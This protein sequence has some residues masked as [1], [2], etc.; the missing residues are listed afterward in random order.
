[1][2]RMPNLCA[3]RASTIVLVAALAFCAVATPRAQP[4][5]PAHRDITYI[6]PLF[7]AVPTLAVMN[8]F[9]TSIGEGPYVRLGFAVYVVIR[10]TDWNVDIHNPAAV[11]TALAST[12]AEIDSNIQQ[13]V[14]LGVPVSLNMV[15][16]SRDAV[17]AV[18]TASQLE[19]RRSMQWFAD[20][21]VGRLVEPFA[22]RTEGARGAGGV[23]SR[24]RP[25]PGEEDGRV[26]RH[27]G[28]G[29]RG[30]RGRAVV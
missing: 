14:D 2:P 26:P 20:N 27:P 28:G 1:M 6:T 17:D 5:I 29:I 4:P 24:G 30:R 3:S 13:G 15:T 21:I 25:L 9:K 8:D 11:R 23:R 16:P 19:D 22:L 18:Q 12:F 10:M 7:P